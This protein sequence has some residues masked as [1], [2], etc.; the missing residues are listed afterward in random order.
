M[1]S[2]LAYFTGLWEKRERG[3]ISHTPELWDSRAEEW[4]GG[5]EGRGGGRHSM[6]DRVEAAALYLRNRG[7]LGGNA[8]VIDVGCGPGLFVTKFA[9]TAGSVT[10]IDYSARFIEYA[11]RYAAAQGVENVA[12]RRCDFTALDID[13]EGLAGAFDLVFTSITP[14]ASGRGC[15]DKLMRMSRG[16]CYNASFVYAEDDLAE[17]V[18]LDVFGER[19]AS[20]WNGRGF[21]ALTNLLWLSGYYPETTYYDETRDEL[22]T[23]G[24]SPAT[25]L[26]SRCGREGGDDARRVLQYLEKAGEI[27]R[28]SRFRYGAILWD[29]T[30]RDRR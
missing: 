9:E 13:A 8:A 10:G 24:L 21:Y 22:V 12:F 2:D 30:R 5:L 6:R 4:I 27:R 20:R 28:R 3:P 16:W 23:P 15:L 11:E 29:V 26:A 14:A 19:F 1:S 18:S 25:E 7:L 17:R